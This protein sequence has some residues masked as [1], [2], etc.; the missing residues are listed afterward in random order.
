MKRQLSYFP[1]VLHELLEIH[2]WYETKSTG[3]GFEF[4]RAFFEGIN[5]IKE[6]PF[7]APY[8]NGVDR[9]KFLKKFPYCIYYYTEDYRTI[10]L[11]IFHTSR[12]AKKISKTI[13][14]RRKGLK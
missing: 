4:D 3:L 8:V 5:Q 1:A 10:I 2:E 14:Q 9:R 7:S 13:K 12:A 6:F 11:A